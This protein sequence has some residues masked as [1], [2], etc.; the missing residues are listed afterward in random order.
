MPQQIEV[1]Y[2]ATPVADGGSISLGEIT[3]PS[4]QFTIDVVNVGDSDLDLMGVGVAGGLTHVSGDDKQILSAA[5]SVTLTYDT[6]RTTEGSHQ[7]VLNALSDDPTNPNHSVVVNYS[8]PAAGATPST[9]TPGTPWAAGSNAFS[10][11]FCSQV[12]V[13]YI[14]S[15][16]GVD[17]RVDDD[18]TGSIEADEE[19]T[20]MT[21]AI[22][23]GANEIVSL[24]SRKYLM[25][26]LVGNKFLRDANAALAACWLARRRGN[27]VPGS[28]QME[29][30][31]YRE[32]LKVYAGYGSL[33]L[34]LPPLTLPGAVP[35]FSAQPLVVSYAYDKW[36]Q[37]AKVRRIEETSTPRPAAPGERRFSA[38]RVP[39]HRI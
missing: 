5:A 33:E 2:L 37:K 4:D 9:L 35:M 3:L 10:Y 39:F 19:A 31:Y 8:A 30:D 21:R 24:L 28:I 17:W 14:W 13:D 1:R 6:T 34:G 11:T 7:G 15:S 36:Q 20:W 38:R 12:D 25:E 27:A 32:W 26:P 22:E 23:Q 29:C 18:E 16:Q